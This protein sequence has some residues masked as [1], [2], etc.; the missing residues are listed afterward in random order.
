MPTNSSG[1]INLQISDP[2]QF[3]NEIANRYGSTARI[4]MEYVDNALDDAEVMF[5][6]NNGSYPRAVEINV[7]IDRQ[8]RAVTVRD[9]C[10]GMNAESLVRI[11]SSV[12]E[13]RKKTM[14]WLNGRF[15]FGVH[16]FRACAKRVRFRTQCADGSTL[17]LEFGRD[18]HQIPAPGPSDP[19]GG[20]G[21]EVTL[22]DF[23]RDWLGELTVQSVRSEIEKHFD[24]LLSRPGIRVTI[25]E[26]GGAVEQARPFDYGTVE[27]VEF[28][29]EVAIRTP[30]RESSVAVRLK[31]TKDPCADRRATFFA[32]GRR[33]VEVHQDHDFIRVSSRRTSLWAHPN[34]IGFIEV[35]G[36]V[37]PAIT[38]DVFKRTKSRELLYEELLKLEDEINEQLHVVNQQQQQ[39]DLR[40]VAD[41]I[42]RELAR[43]A[44]EDRIRLRTAPTAGTGISSPSQGG[45]EAEEGFGGPPQGDGAGGSDPGVVDGNDSGPTNTGPGI[46]PGE[47][48]GNSGGAQVGTGAESGKRKKAGFTIEFVRWPST[49]GGS[50]IRS[51]LIDGV[52]MINTLHPQFG[53]RVKTTRTGRMK[54]TDRLI[55]YVAGVVS[56]HYKDAFYEKYRRQPDKRT[57][58]FD[59][60]L[61]F[62]CRME[63]SLQ[64]IKAEIQSM[65]DSS[66]EEQGEA[67]STLERES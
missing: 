28:N 63:V 55:S 64:N 52:I 9:N 7:L 17:G 44:R 56:I 31:V 25:A 58:L 20:T 60:Q 57:Q 8:N 67:S 65:L 50:P 33:I 27:G 32:K 23:D 30:G 12:G 18:A 22:L 21:T 53:E 48:Q 59:D 41:L 19:I 14:S 49:E 45:S 10:S 15:G 13:S 11:V 61:E 46:P 5:R 2:A 26:V 24:L 16:A 40:K 47:G 62:V 34:L 43:L 35:G 29:R 54:M 1:F 51:N 6:E 42:E 36:A 38:R 39:Q 3:L 37:E 4:L 66:E